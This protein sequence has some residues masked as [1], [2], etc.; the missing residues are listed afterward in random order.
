MCRRVEHLRI[1]L[2][3]FNKYLPSPSGHRRASL[4]AKVKP[5]VAHVG[6]VKVVSTA[7]PDAG[8]IVELSDYRQDQALKFLREH[9]YG[10]R[11]KRIPGD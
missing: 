8:D 7:S 10:E 11:H 9:L 1:I 2:A 4:A 5:S 6:V 3:F